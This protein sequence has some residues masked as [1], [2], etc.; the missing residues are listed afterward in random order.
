MVQIDIQ[1]E[2]HPAGRWVT[3]PIVVDGSYALSPVLDTGSPVSAISP[4]IQQELENRRL[5]GPSAIPRRYLLSEI[6]AQS[7]SL[8][9]LDVAVL[10]RLDRI[11]VDGL[12]GLDFLTQFESIHFHTRSLRLVLER[13]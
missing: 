10:P 13:A 11:G 2:I 3:I 1:A 12:L 6:A 7:Q 8:P 4:R 5:L 9:D